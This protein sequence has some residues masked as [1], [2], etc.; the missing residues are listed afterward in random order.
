MSQKTKTYYR[1]GLFSNGKGGLLYWYPP[2]GADVIE[3]GYCHLIREGQAHKIFRSFHRRGLSVTRLGR[4][5]DSF[6]TA[7]GDHQYCNI[8]VLE[9]Y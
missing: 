1:I 3:R 5:R 8:D 6:V 9:A 4:R 7:S 2:Y